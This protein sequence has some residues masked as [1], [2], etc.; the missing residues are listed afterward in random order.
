MRCPHCG[1]ESFAKKKK[2]TENWKV[3]GEIQVCALCGKK[4]GENAPGGTAGKASDGNKSRLAALLGG[5]LTEKVELA[6]SVDRKFCRNCRYFLVHPFK[7]VCSLTDTEA[8]PMGECGRFEE[9]AA[10]QNP[11]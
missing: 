1:E 10:V 2:I 6:G 5:D 8:D 3:V 4:W 11:S 7:T 9:R